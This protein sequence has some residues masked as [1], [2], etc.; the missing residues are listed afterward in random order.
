MAGYALKKL[1]EQ[2]PAGLNNLKAFFNWA[3][4]RDSE[5]DIL[6]SIVRNL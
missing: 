2:Y 5:H 1:E 6:K 3:K 4:D